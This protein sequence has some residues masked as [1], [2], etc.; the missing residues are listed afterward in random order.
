[1]WAADQGNTEI[2]VALV[3]KGAAM[4][5]QDKAV[6]WR[7]DYCVAFAKSVY[8]Q[9][10]RVDG[11]LTVYATCMLACWSCRLHFESDVTSQMRH[12]CVCMCV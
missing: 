6:R 9:I 8:V 5:V 12:V 3:E 4:D 1:M 10:I 2:A 11:F 7:G